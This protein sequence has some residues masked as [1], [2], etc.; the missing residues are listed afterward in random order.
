MRALTS[1]LR[2]LLRPRLVPDPCLEQACTS[3]AS[4]LLTAGSVAFLDCCISSP[5]VVGIFRSD[6]VQKVAHRTPSALPR[7]YSRCLSCHSRMLLPLRWTELACRDVMLPSREPRQFPHPT[8][9]SP[10]AL[11]AHR[12]DQ[13]TCAQ[14]ALR[15]PHLLSDMGC[16]TPFF[17]FNLTPSEMAWTDS[18]TS[19]AHDD[20]IHPSVRAHPTQSQFG[21]HDNNTMQCKLERKYRYQ[22]YHQI[23]SYVERAHD[24]ESLSVTLLSVSA[25]SWSRRSLSC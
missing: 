18:D 9:H 8:F 1:G 13:P 6:D 21:I 25:V 11:H 2:V 22:N 5:E 12:L 17:R 16:N 15:Y 24:S 20:P 23:K 14:I 7:K 3:Q 10:L 4:L 19:L